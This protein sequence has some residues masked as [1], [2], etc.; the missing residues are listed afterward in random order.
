MT[1]KNLAPAIMKAMK[2]YGDANLQSTYER[3]LAL[4]VCYPTGCTCNYNYLIDRE[5]M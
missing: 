1:S 2:I 3:N 5:A 4:L